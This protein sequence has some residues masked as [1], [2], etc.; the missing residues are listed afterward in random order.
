M[1]KSENI[2]E[3]AIALSKTQAT[4]KPAPMNATNPFLKNKYADLGAVI[5][6][7]RGVLASNGLSVSQ[8]VGGL[9]DEISVTTVLMHTSGQWLESTVSMSVGEERGKS[10]A[11]V[12]GSIITYLRRYSLASILGMYADEDTDG[13]NVKPA[14][15][16]VQN[17]GHKPSGISLEDAVN[18]L[19]SAGVKYGDLPN[20]KLALM[21]NQL[22]KVKNPTDDQLYK[23]EVI[24]IIMGAR[25]VEQASEP[26]LIETAEK[27]GGT[28]TAE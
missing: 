5:E 1:S 10:A 18:H 20:D 13:N 7:S 26:S 11:Q 19:N 28:A 12:A 16:K 3:L 6:T 24:K 23:I 17:N 2:N 8:L 25:S 9:G 22:A 4:M 15:N 27:L 21:F 14:E